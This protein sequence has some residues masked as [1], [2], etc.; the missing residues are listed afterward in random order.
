MTR[1][2]GRKQVLL[3]LAAVLL[4]GAGLLARLALA[5]PGDPTF[6]ACIDQIAGGDC[7]T[8]AGIA[9][10]G[11]FG[12]AASPDGKSVYVASYGSDSISHFTRAADGSLGFQSC[13]DE[14]AG[15][16]CATPGG[17]AL[18]DPYNVAVSPDG[19]S[20]Y[21]TATT[22]EAVNHFSR[23]ADGSLTFVGCD[24]E[25]AIEGC[26]TSPA[27]ALDSAEGVAASA[28]GKSVYV[29]SGGAADSISHFS[30]AL[31]GS[32]TFDECFDETGGAPCATPA[33]VALG[34]A[35]GVAASADG[36][37]VYVASSADDSVS[38]FARAADG[39][40]TF[41][42]CIDETVGGDCSTPAGAAL[43]S[44]Y[45][46]AVSADGTSVYVPSANSDSIS[47]FTRAADGS[48]TLQA[49]IAETAAEGCASP[50]GVSLSGAENLALSVDGKSVYVSSLGSNSI[51]H[52][53][54]AA[55][56]SL[57]FV[58]C[59][60]DAAG[61]DCATPAGLALLS[62][63]GVAASADGKSVYV[64]GSD[65][66]SINHFARELPRCRGKVV[67]AFGRP[68]S[69][70]IAGTAGRDVIAGL[71]GRDRIRG[72][73]G[74]DLLCGGPGNDIL[75]G[76]AGN[77][78]LAGEAGRDTLRGG[79]GRDLLIGGPRPD[80]CQGGPGRDRQRTC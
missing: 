74:K 68:T 47:H 20:V 69:E 15:P 53:A 13:I 57:A 65:D 25:T 27:I 63:Y 34:S 70:T 16:P 72:L 26:A 2:R 30:R 36:K 76:A 12:A 41:Q 56:G 8:P 48:L 4:V 19:A 51:S 46:V 42:D 75:V 21:V 32:L 14:T 10:D 62:P 24:G 43:G 35:Q 1:S 49:C 38:H 33:G 80:R 23:A 28:D 31:D 60:D 58:T 64:V 7:A 29:A 77:D 66:D 54:R 11:P 17:V 55:D 73:G 71:G 78:T 40:L 45:N 6:Q 44:A 50:P 52:F 18:V 67:T 39:S 9:I 37:S 79:A 5:A 22:S 59:I 61:G 3:A